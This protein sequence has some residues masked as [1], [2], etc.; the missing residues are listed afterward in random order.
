VSLGRVGTL[1]LAVALTGSAMLAEPQ[2][3]NAT[4]A[5]TA[6]IDAAD[7]FLD[8]Y[9]QPSGRIA[10]LDEGGDT[11]SEAQAY[12][13]LMAVAVGDEQRLRRIW[14]W[15]DE[16]LQRD[17]GLLAWR[18]ADGGIVDYQSA[19][20]ADILAA[21]ALALGGARFGDDD[22]IADARS[23]NDAVHAHE[24]AAFGGS[25]VLLAGPWARSTRT[26][27]PGYLATPAMSL[28]WET[29]GDQRWSP[30]AAWSRG[31]LADL[32]AEPPH[33]PADWATV[34]AAGGNPAARSSPAGDT[35]RYGY[36]ATRAIVQSAADCTG[37]GQALAARTWRFLGGEADG[38][39]VAATYALDG[40]QLDD[41]QHPVALVAAAA[42]AAAS[43]ERDRAAEL[44]DAADALDARSPSY[45]GSAW[46]AL[47]RLWLETDLLGGCRPGSPT[48]P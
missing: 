15:T 32:T 39:T 18:W 1:A 27:N 45:F 19:A 10:R 37:E 40:Q 5:D 48:H 17:D 26:I 33:L 43:G 9:L 34:D 23:I 42:A 20:D 14:A 47:A 22:L 8:R 16:H 2:S 13:M 7:E 28:L 12:G 21:A 29:L 4:G 6:A 11:V 44:L 25:P 36:E 31:V 38:G 24:I 30:V 3:T 35:P 41:E 46:I